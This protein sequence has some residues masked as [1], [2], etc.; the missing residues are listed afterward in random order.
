MLG[1]LRSKRGTGCSG[2]VQ[3]RNQLRELR[4]TQPDDWAQKFQDNQNLLMQ[5]FELVCLEDM[6]GVLTDNRRRI[7]SELNANGELVPP[8]A[9][10]MPGDLKL[11][12]TFNDQT[13]SG[14]PLALGLV[15]AA[16]LLAVALIAM[17]WL[18]GKQAPAAQPAQ[19]SMTIPPAKVKFRIPYEYN[20]ETE[21]LDI[22]IKPEPTS[23]GPQ[24][25][26]GDED[27]V[28][29]SG[30]GPGVPGRVRLVSRES[31]GAERDYAQ[32][33]DRALAEVARRPQSAGPRIDFTASGLIAA[34]AILAGG[35]SVAI[36]LL[37]DSFR[38]EA[39]A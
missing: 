28:A 2:M 22:E 18:M 14:W 35:V 34:V 7:N 27:I 15:A 32:P 25:T 31:S 9:D 21:K 23:N 13:S 37:V 12:D 26:A 16:L 3:K 6:R 19:P 11:G 24:E 29:R 33:G 5:G 38:G 1:W 20:P 4:R 30:F 36:Y 39:G 8:K 17:A 10:T